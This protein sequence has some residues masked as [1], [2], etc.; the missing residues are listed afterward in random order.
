MLID[1]KELSDMIDK[2]L[3]KMLSSNEG[4]RT[5]IKFVS[6]TVHAVNG[7][8]ARLKKLEAAQTAPRSE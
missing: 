6:K 5:L 8:D 2:H 4:V 3:P 7:L 1:I